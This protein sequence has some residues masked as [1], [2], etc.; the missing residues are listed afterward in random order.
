MG[1]FK[2]AKQ[3]AQDAMSMGAGAQMPPGMP[4][5]PGGMPDM[6]N[7]SMPDPAYVA[8]VNKIGQ[9]GVEAPGEIKAIRPMGG[10]DM[11]GAIQHE[12]DVTVRPAGGAAY[13][14][15]IQQSMLPMQMEGLSEGKA[16]T[17]KYDPD[18]PTD[19]LLTSW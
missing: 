10:P 19:A 11:S 18:Q 5:M 15:T 14:T 1:L 3:R 6:A 4:E 13:D 12:F 17:V 8:K 2:D 16:V 9:S 7:M